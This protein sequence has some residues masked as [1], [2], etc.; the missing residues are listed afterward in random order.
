MHASLQHRG[1]SVIGIVVALTLLRSAAH[2]DVQPSAILANPPPAHPHRILVKYRST[3]TKCAHCSLARSVPFAGVTGSDSLDRLNRRFQIRGAHALFFDNHGSKAPSAAYRNALGA[4]RSRFP[5]RAA[6]S[7]AGATAPDLS[8]IFVLDIGNADPAAAAAAFAA[9]P[10]VEYAEPDYQVRVSLTPNDPYFSSSGSWGQGF[11]DL[12]GLQ[13]THAASAWD[14]S[15][16]DG[17]I[18]A[19]I[20]TGVLYTHPD[21]KNNVWKNPREIPNNRIDDDGNGY[22]DDVYGWD[23]VLNRKNPTDW[24]GHGTHVAGTIAATGNNGI[25]VVGMAWGAR[26]MALRGLNA[27]GIGYVSNLAKAIVYAAQNGADVLNNSWGGGFPSLTIGDAVT[28][29]VSLGAIVVFAAGNSDSPCD[30]G[31]LTGDAT[32]PRVIAVAATTPDDQRAGFS[33]HG[34]AISVA[35][36]GVN[37]LS[38]AGPGRVGGKRVGARYRVLSGTSMA[39]PHVA[40]LTALLLSAMPRLTLD[41]VRWHLELNADQLGY[42]GYEEQPWNPYLGWGRINA[43]RVFDLPPLTTRIKTS[44]IELHGFAGAVVPDAASVQFTFT[45]HDPVAWSASGPAWL[46]PAVSSGTGDA[47]VSLTFDGS[48]FPVGT[49]TG[50]VTVA[51]PAA[52][53]GGGSVASTAYLHRDN[54]VGTDVVLTDSY[55]SFGGGPRVASDGHGLLAVWVELPL[56]GGGPNLVGAH[57]DDLGTVTG[58]FMLDQG[59]CIGA[60]CFLKF[61]SHLAVAFDG[62]NFLVV[63]HEEIQGNVSET[64]LRKKK[65]EYVKAVRVTP[66]GQVLDVPPIEVAARTEI[67]NPD[68]SYDEFYYN[69]DLAFDGTAYTALWGKLNYAANAVQPVQ[70]FVRRIGTNGVLLAPTRQIYPLATTQYP[71]FIEPKV[72]CVSGSCLIAWHEADGETSPE[73]KYIDKLYGQRF[74]GD[75][76]TDVTPFRFLTDIED[77]AVLASSGAGYFAAGY[78]A[79]VC[80]GP[81]I[82]GYDIVG[83]RVSASGTALDPTGIR[84]NNSLSPNGSPQFINPNAIAFDGTNYIVTWGKIDTAA[85]GGLTYPFAARVGLDGSVL[86]TESE[87]LLLAPHMR[88]GSPVLAATATQTLM[89]WPEGGMYSSRLVARGIFPH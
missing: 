40:G 24:H 59:R 19:V 7:P 17:V 6:R 55:Y 33:N 43:A 73:G 79:T 60:F 2:A 13:T 39:A 52:V 77:M 76:A 50:A 32:D 82:C 37:V 30:S 20:D 21:L 56:S 48:G 67:A 74:A 11:A 63:W 54:R 49:Y 84:L 87:G 29:A 8:N 65:Q 85:V 35:A 10:D 26:V 89:V 42:P 44:P 34:S 5:V 72:A 88:W 47:T 23:F 57:V 3:M 62:S 81:K 53:D 78:R 1:V 12:W 4:V 80:P 69:L 41:D 75:V 86:D 25:G 28:T 46:T 15:R 14:T 68:N 9:D 36:P 61:G 58:P 16:G 31:V 64:S 70:V 18:V 38:L 71:Q 27:R 45:T 22:V 83:A 66:S 51:A